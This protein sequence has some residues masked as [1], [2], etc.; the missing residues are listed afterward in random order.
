MLSVALNHVWMI[1]ESS[2]GVVRLESCWALA[3]ASL[4]CVL[5]QWSLAGEAVR[6]GWGR[7]A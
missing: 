7:A 5:L 1:F 2:G 6:L 4:L 3:C